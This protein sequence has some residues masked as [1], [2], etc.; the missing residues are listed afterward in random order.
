MA[1]AKADIKQSDEWQKAVAYE[2]T[3]ADIER[4]RKLLGFDQAAKTREYITV[5]TEDNIRNFAHGIG[6]DKPLYTDPGYAKKTRWGSV[7][8]PG[9]M[10]GIINKPMLGDPVPDEIKALRKSLFK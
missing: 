3:D 10:A 2:I 6:D 8:A 1:N 7:I 5:A 9:M 4:Q